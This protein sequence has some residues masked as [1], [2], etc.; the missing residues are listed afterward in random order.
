MLL[1]CNCIFVI[2]L[3]FDQKFEGDDQVLLV[4][5]EELVNQP[6]IYPQIDIL[7]GALLLKFK[8]LFEA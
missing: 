5:Y 8:Q 6:D 3:F 4:S 7:C 2:F 1:R